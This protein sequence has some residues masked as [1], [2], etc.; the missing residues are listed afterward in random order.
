MED[1]KEKFLYKTG[2]SQRVNCDVYVVCTLLFALAV[3][4]PELWDSVFVYK[5]PHSKTA[6]MFAAKATMVIASFWVIRAWLRVY[7]HK[8]QITNERFIEIEGILSRTTRGLE[9]FRVKDITLVEPLALRALG[10]GDIIMDTSD[11]SNPV[12]V[13][14]AIKNP[15]YV[16]EMLRR[17][18]DN[19]RTAKG[20]GMREMEV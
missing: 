2:P 14:H 20:V 11:K 13:V 12:V 10:L 15:L 18:V 19:M 17:H 1:T 6:Y 7:C 16:M 9:L 5:I 4:A 3:F 8:Y